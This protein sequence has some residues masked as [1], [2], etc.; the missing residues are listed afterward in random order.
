MHKPAPHN[1]YPDTRYV[2]GHEGLGAR[3]TSTHPPYPQSALEV[4]NPQNTTPTKTR[5]VEHSDNSSFARTQCYLWSPKDQIATCK[6]SLPSGSS[7]NADNNPFSFGYQ[8]AHRPQSGVVT[9]S[10]T[11]LA[12]TEEE[13]LEEGEL[14][15]DTEQPTTPQAWAASLSTHSGSISPASSLPASLPPVS[16]SVSPAASAHS[17]VLMEDDTDYGMS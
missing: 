8:L 1:E 6:S 17:D 7:L 3:V 4:D 13:E 16:R 9:H 2:T 14:S 15:P 10:A 12:F 11:P 5:K